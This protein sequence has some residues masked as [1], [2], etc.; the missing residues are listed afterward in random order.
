MNTKTTPPDKLSI[1]IHAGEFDKIHYALV[2]ASAAAA[3][4][5]PVTLFFTMGACAV[6]KS[7]NAWKTLSCSCSHLTPEQMNNA[8]KAKG[9]ATFDELVEACVALGVKFMVCEM[10]LRAVDLEDTPLRED[11]PIQTGGVVTFL[12]DSS[13]HG[14]ML[15]I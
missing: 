3:I 10:G 11:I 13:R 5:T 6:L 15:F 8:Y 4:S 1:V 9:V 7:E 12:N 2:M 14:S